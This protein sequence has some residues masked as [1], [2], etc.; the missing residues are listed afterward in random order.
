MVRLDKDNRSDIASY[1]CPTRRI[2]YK[3]KDHATC[4]HAGFDKKELA[5]SD[6]KE[7]A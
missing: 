3:E 4:L 2:M 5:E 6:K 1:W 7:Q